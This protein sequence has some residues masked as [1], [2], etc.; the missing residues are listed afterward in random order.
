MILLLLRVILRRN[1]AA[2]TGVTIVLGAV[3]T[4]DLYGSA[5]LA[6]PAFGTVVAKNVIASAVPAVVFVSLL[7]FVCFRF[8]LVAGIAAMFVEHN[9]IWGAQ[10][11]DMSTWWAGDALV[12]LGLLV[13]LIL[14]AFRISL[15]G[16]PLLKVRILEE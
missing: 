13:L 11:L 10:T 4:A 3:M 2:I 16:R 14:Y 7:V 12:V 8:G 5:N 6:A 9:L 15:A 1:W